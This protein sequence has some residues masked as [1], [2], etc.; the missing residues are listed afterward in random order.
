MGNL[1]S[2]GSFS[3]FEI[4]FCKAIAAATLGDSSNVEYVPATAGNRFDLLAS[5][6]I[7]VLIRTTTWTF[8]RDIDLDANFETTTFYDGQGMMVKVDPGFESLKDMDGASI[9]VT[10]GTTTEQNIDDAFEAICADYPPRRR[11]R[12]RRAGELPRR[13]L[14]R[15]LVNGRNGDRPWEAHREGSAVLRTGLDGRSAAVSLDDTLHDRE[16]ESGTVGAST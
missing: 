12:R 14:R 7:D 5:G 3:G 16:S 15:A 11:G 2:D 6:E 4:E 8:S 13:P 10:T 1:E 9:C